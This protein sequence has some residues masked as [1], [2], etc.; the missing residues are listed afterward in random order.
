MGEGPEPSVRQGV[1]DP[2]PGFIAGVM[3]MGGK[4]EPFLAACLESIRDAVDLLVLNENSGDPANPNME[5][6]RA[7]SLW[8][9][10]KVHL[11]ESEFKGFG[12]CRTLCLD[13]IGTIY[14]P[15]TWVLYI[16]CDEVH[17]SGITAVTRAILPH[18]PET[19]GIVDGYFYQFFQTTE[20]YLSL[21]RR[22]NL[23]FRYNPEIRW[24]GVVHEK[25]VGMAGSREAIPY[26]YFHYG[27]LMD[28]RDLLKK[29]K[30]YTDLGDSGSCSDAGRVD[31]IVMGHV[32]AVLPY[33]G[34]HPAVAAQCLAAVTQ[35]E[36]VRRFTERARREPRGVG[37]LLQG[38]NFAMR[39]HS[40]Y[41]Q[42]V[43]KYGG[44]GAL[45]RGLRELAGAARHP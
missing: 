32:K 4:S 15:G 16:D 41:L 9:A 36:Y 11:I 5:V 10:G 37:Q 44:D 12:F 27:Y 39:L 13:Y 8:K 18:L 42:Y 38:L 28:P 23:F 24:E 17:P 3:M 22:H 26:P 19:V 31:E 1:R 33:R 45:M 2:G 25:P 14:K 40:R 43:M 35:Q 20:F 29:W 21:D 34:G 6:V 7:S 30:L